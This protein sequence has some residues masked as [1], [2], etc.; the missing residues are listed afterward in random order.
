MNHHEV[1][2]IIPTFN[3]EES[4][5]ETIIRLQNVLNQNRIDAEILVVDDE[6]TD[7]TIEIVGKLQQTRYSNI[8][9]IVRHPPETKDLALSI[10]WG[11]KNTESPYICVTDGDGSHEIEKIPTMYNAILNGADIAIGSRYM[12]GGGVVGWPTSRYILSRGAT[13]L[14]RLLFPYLTD[15]GNFFMFRK[16]VINGIDLHAHGFKLSVEIIDKGKWE[17]LQQIPYTFTNRKKGKSKLKS[18]IITDFLLEMVDV[19]KN[20]VKTRNTRAWTEIESSLKFTLVGAVG[21]GVNLLLLYL[22]TDVFGFYYMISGVIAVAISIIT[23]FILNDVFSFGNKSGLKLRKNARFCVYSSIALVGI[24]INL[25]S[26]FVL[27]TYM[28][29]YYL[30]SS[31]FGILVAYGWNLIMNRRITWNIE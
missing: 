18:T 16:D 15:P 19:V 3:E 31:F 25:A 22:F 14:T 27:T 17:K 5:E 13:F 6:S 30:F 26:L 29:V 28:G 21:V 23:N 7:R 9:F 4:I 20:A 2:V 10:V 1:C 8:R 11:F 12:P 24:T